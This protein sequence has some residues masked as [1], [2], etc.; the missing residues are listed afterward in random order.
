M[1]NFD[2]NSER[3]LQI[4]K[5]TAIL[6]D[7]FELGDAPVRGFFTDG[8][9]AREM[10]GL[11]DSFIVSKIHRTEHIFVVSKGTMTVWDDEN[12]EV[13]IQAPYIGITKPGT[14][15]FAYVWPYDD[16]IWT[17]FHANPDNETVDQIEE[18]I[19]EPHNNLFLT[20]ELKSK[21][22]GVKHKIENIYKTL[23][24]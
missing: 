19:I 7:N 24:Y 13:I 18:R 23:N 17:T 14:R 22:L 16:C 5:L 8:L 6:A 21:L 3:N 11:A 4:D 12:T 20:D 10:T 2:H 15:R 9:Y 1:K